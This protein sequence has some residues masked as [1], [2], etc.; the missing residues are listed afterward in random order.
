MKKN[1]CLP[2]SLLALAILSSC[3]TVPQNTALSNAHSRYSEARANPDVT[4]LAALELK[5]AG[6][7]LSKADLAVNAGE[8]EDKINQ[9][10]YLATQRVGIAQENAKRKTA[11]LAVTNAGV[12]RTEVRLEARTAEADAAKLLIMQL[13]ELNAQKTERGM[14]ITLGDVLFN[15][16]M[17]R[18][19]P[20]GI[21]N[22]QKLAD[23]MAQY[24]QNK[25]SVEGYTDSTGSD[26]HNQAL[27]ERRAAA[28][29]K[30][31]LDMGISGDRVATSG[32]GED[33][34]V[35]SNNSADSR[36][37]NRR[38]EIILSDANGHIAPR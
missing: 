23:F 18:L 4:N 1:N 20:D 35:A 26:S 2:L 22:V 28:V 33:Y 10:A 25:V 27:S 11:E 8:S 34:P 30:A 24:P 12:K 32:Y 5:D 6:D 3:A 38:V 17:A 21:S 9:L 29:Q 15:T 13:K 31:L 36:Q 7:T 19:K 14:V 37:L 16:D